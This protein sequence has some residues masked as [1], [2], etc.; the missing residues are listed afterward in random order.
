VCDIVH[1]NEVINLSLLVCHTDISEKYQNRFR[2]YWDNF[3]HEGRSRIYWTTSE[4]NKGPEFIGTSL[5][6][7]FQIK[8]LDGI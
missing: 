5:E 8:S 2:T 6:I 3:R 7:K 1:A 4:K